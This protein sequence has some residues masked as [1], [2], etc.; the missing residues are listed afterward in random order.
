MA[1]LANSAE[2]RPTR[3]LKQIAA[4]A[5]PNVWRMFD[6]ARERALASGQSWP[7]YMWMPLEDLAAEIMRSLA[8]LMIA[9][10]ANGQTVSRHMPFAA[11][12]AYTLATWRLGKGVYRFDDDVRQALLETPVTGD[13]P[14]DVLKR[15]PEWCVYVE[16][17]GFRPNDTEVHGFFACVTRFNG[18]E[19][20][21]LTMDSQDPARSRL[22]SFVP[23]GLSHRT[24][25]DALRWNV[26]RSIAVTKEYSQRGVPFAEPLKADLARAESDPTRLE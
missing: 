1:G 21:P 24:I 3:W 4:A 26:T 20:L 8:K 25:E 16:T 5:L 22:I 17:P 23:I 13:I 7:G 12:N 19:V 11:S 10:H 14:T 6:E 15:L 2:V 9:Q 18:E